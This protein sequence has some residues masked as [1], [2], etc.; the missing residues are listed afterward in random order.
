MVRVTVQEDKR[1]K[2]GSESKVE[3]R[4]RGSGRESFRSEGGGKGNDE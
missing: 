3:K 4:E 2:Y 1:C